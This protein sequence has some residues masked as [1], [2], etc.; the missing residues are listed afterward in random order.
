MIQFK[1][2]TKLNPTQTLSNIT[3]KKSKSA[4]ETM[5]FADFVIDTLVIKK[6]ISN[7]NKTT[8]TFRIYPLA[9]PA[10][11]N[12]LYNLVYRLVNGKWETS[13]FYLKKFPKNTSNQKIF[14]KIERIDGRVTTPSA[15]KSASFTMCPIESFTLHCTNTGQCKDTGKCDGCSLCVSRSITYG[16]CDGGGGSGGGISD[17]GVGGSPS[18]GGGTTDP[19]TYNPNTYDNPVYDDPEYIYRSKREQ[20]WAALYEAQRFFAADEN[21][22]F[23]NETLEYQRD[24]NWSPES[25]AFGDAARNFKQ[26]N[27]EA[28]FEDAKDLLLYQVIVDPSFK[29]NPYLYGIY[30]QLGQ[31]E[32]FQNYLKKFDGKFSVANLKFAASAVLASNINAQTSPPSNYLITINFNENNLNRPRLDIARTFI[33]EM[34]HTEMFR[35][36]LS[37]SSTNAEI[38]VIK[39]NRMLTE[40]N[41]PGLYDYYRRYGVNN[42]QHEQMAAHYRGI[43]VDFLKEYNSTLTNE[44]YQAIAWTQMS[45]LKRNEITDLYNTWYLGAPQNCQ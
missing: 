30:K 35:T 43:I 4:K 32:I 5:V 11:P 33:H 8:Y 7:T 15:A 13:I 2:E 3:A 1:N 18:S 39:L 25:A 28:S 45:D 26:L 42:M 23:F 19:Y 22:G 44:Q 21:I 38:D 27:P 40:H 10:Q 41:Y 6:Y 34:I 37:L 20:I 9:T 16:T 14:E 36:L 29:N 17:P 31:A 12:E 24:N